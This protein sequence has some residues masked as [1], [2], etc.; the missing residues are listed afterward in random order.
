MLFRSKTVGIGECGHRIIC[1]I[2]LL[3]LRWVMNKP[4]C[5]ICKAPLNTLYITSDPTAKF[6]DFPR[7]GNPLIKDDTD[8]NVFFEDKTAY[9]H[10]RHLKDYYC[11]IEECYKRMY[12]QKGLERHLKSQHNRV[13]CQICFKNRPVF[14]GEQ[15]IY[16]S[17]SLGD[18]IKYGE[19]R[20][21]LMIKP[22]PLCTFC[23]QYFYTEEPLFEHLSKIHMNCH[24]CGEKHKYIFYKDY[25]DL[26]LHFQKTHYLCANEKCKNKC[27]VVFSTLEELHIH[28]YKEHGGFAPTKG[29]TMDAMRAGLFSTDDNIGK[30]DPGDLIG[31]DF[32]LYYDPYFSM[33]M[34][35]ELKKKEMNKDK[36][37]ER[38][39]GTGRRGKYGRGGYYEDYETKDNYNNKEDKKD[40]TKKSTFPNEACIE[41]LHGEL[42]AII[43]KKLAVTKI[44]NNECNFEK[45]QLYQL[46]GLIDT[47]SMEKVIQCEFLMNFGITLLLKKQLHYLL[48]NNNGHIIDEDEMFSLSIRELLIVYKY[49]DLAVQKINKKYIRH[50]LSDINENLLAEF[51]GGTEKSKARKE[52][53]DIRSALKPRLDFDDK[54]AFPEL[55]GLSKKEDNVNNIWKKQEKI[56]ENKGDKHKDKK[57][58]E[59]EFPALPEKPPNLVHEEKKKEVKKSLDEEYWP[60]LEES[61]KHDPSTQSSGKGKKNRNRKKKQDTGKPQIEIGFY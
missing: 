13:I 14:P 31:I 37:K 34:Q 29:L 53:I 6:E 1:Y 21:D 51:N 2:C 61:D 35:E 30:K 16:P 17:H 7:E 10:I 12:D 50:D 40:H 20:N 9:E 33:K 26:E 8:P 56:L 52:I 36:F 44:A 46:C 58:F 45:E 59:E 22:H 5:P 19:N 43:I 11:P 47:M 55:G 57:G 25:K 24:L 41:Q 18:H 60:T 39:R 4:N 27:F 15:F 32:G 3:R 48:Q 38:G 42:R 49:F 54:K 23:N 28:N